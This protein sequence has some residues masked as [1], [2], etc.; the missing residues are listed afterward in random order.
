M[1]ETMYAAP[2]IGLAANQVGVPYRV[3]VMIGSPADYACFNPKIVGFSNEIVELD[4]GCLSFPNLFVKIKRPRD[5]RVRFTDYNGDVSTHTF[6]GMT[7]RIFQHELDHLDGKLFYNLADRYHREKAI[8][9]AKKQNK[10]VYDKLKIEEERKK[11]IDRAKIN[12]FTAGS[13]NI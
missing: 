2:G 6:T 4:E 5:I 9:Y 8:K 12:W 7:A 3:F 10:I 13:N 11:Q 1:I